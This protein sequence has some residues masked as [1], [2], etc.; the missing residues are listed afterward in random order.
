M[1]T[2]PKIEGR[3]M[4]RVMAGCWSGFGGNQ[5]SENNNIKREIDL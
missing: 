5:H 4:T 2:A 3:E 1:C